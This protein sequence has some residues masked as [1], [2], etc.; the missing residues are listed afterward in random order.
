MCP[1]CPLAAQY[2]RCSACCRA[3][4][5]LTA[6]L[7]TCSPPPPY[8]PSSP[9]P[10]TR[11]AR[12]QLMLLLTMWPIAAHSCLDCHLEP[13]VHAGADLSCA[14]LC[15]QH[16]LLTCLCWYCPWSGLIARSNWQPLLAAALSW[17]KSGV[18]PAV[19]HCPLH[20]H[21]GT[22]ACFC[23][24]SFCVPVLPCCACS[25]IAQLHAHAWVT[26]HHC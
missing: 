23:T 25:L 5:T 3:L 16:L 14:K 26:V 12:L 10:P 1:R 24:D 11:Q 19:C 21:P 13:T 2:C 20:R 18:L 6:L 17:L 15:K 8:P 4:C 9:P 22:A 7:F